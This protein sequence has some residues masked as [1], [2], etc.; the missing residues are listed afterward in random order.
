LAQSVLLVRL[1]LAFFFSRVGPEI[2]EQLVQSLR[3]KLDDAVLDILSVTL[4]RNPHCKLTPED[5]L[6]IQKPFTLPDTVLKVSDFCTVCKSIVSCTQ[7]L[8]IYYV[9]LK[10]F[11]SIE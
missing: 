3:N 5:V 1:C 10:T 8:G 6:F 2:K 11:F 9:F 4:D 7:S